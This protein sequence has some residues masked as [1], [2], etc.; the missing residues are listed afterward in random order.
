MLPARRIWIFEDNRQIGCLPRG[1]KTF[2][3]GVHEL[4]V[5][6]FGATIIFVGPASD[7][8]RAPMGIRF[9]SGDRGGRFIDLAPGAVR[10]AVKDEKFLA[11]RRIAGAV[12]AGISKIFVRPLRGWYPRLR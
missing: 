7:P 1:E 11:V 4:A 12:V 9:E 10:E 5:V 6:P 3:A 2:V 8:T